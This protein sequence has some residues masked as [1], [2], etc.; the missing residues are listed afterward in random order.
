MANVKINEFTGKVVG[1]LDVGREVTQLTITKDE[2]KLILH[3]EGKKEPIAVDISAYPIAF[4]RQYLPDKTEEPNVIPSMFYNEKT[5]TLTRYGGESTMNV[6]RF[7][8]KDK[9]LQYGV[10]NGYVPKK[11]NE[12]AKSRVFKQRY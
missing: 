3:L 8:E 6:F 7:S 5:N 9:N 4:L 2:K 12:D 11:E 10:Y 1:D